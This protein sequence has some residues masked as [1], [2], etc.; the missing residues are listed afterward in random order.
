MNKVRLGSQG[1][2]V[3]RMGLGCM[4]MSEVVGDRYGAAHMRAI[5]RASETAR[6]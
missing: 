4:G 5:D 3:S 1:A 2:V 6:G